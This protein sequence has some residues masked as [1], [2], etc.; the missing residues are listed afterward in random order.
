MV[1]GW[2]VLDVSFPC[3]NLCLLIEDGL[4][5][6]RERQGPGHVR[7]RSH[8][9]G[10]EHTRL[11]RAP[12]RS[13][14]VGERETLRGSVRQRVAAVGRA[15][16]HSWPPCVGLLCARGGLAFAIVFVRIRRGLWPPG[17]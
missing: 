13:H 7:G 5:T 14:G 17:V 8:Q 3:R 1:Y 11:A 16:I 12:L 4:G 10:L 15:T 2:S 6:G 9:L